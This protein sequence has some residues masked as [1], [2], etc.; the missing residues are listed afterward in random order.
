MSELI[1]VYITEDSSL[2]CLELM[3]SVHLMLDWSHLNISARSRE[4]RR[5]V[6]TKGS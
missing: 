4:K 5:N 1:E 6:E 2:G 3:A